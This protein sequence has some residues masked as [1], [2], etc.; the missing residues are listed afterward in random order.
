MWEIFEHYK[1]K[2]V[3]IKTSK[4]PKLLFSRV[5]CFNSNSTPKRNYA[6]RDENLVYT[7]YFTQTADTQNKHIK[8]GSLK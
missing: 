1:T 6:R 3:S 4:A 5:L 7:N 8:Q 2:C